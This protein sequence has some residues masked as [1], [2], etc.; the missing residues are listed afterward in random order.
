MTLQAC[1]G[2][3]GAMPIDAAA[4]RAAV[5]ADFTPVVDSEGARLVVR[6]AGC[7]RVRVG[8]R[9]RHQSTAPPT[10]FNARQ[11]WGLTARPAT[12]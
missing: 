11:R 3:V 8:V 7:R 2:F 1:T 4:A 10:R 5:P 6:V 12:A 9:D